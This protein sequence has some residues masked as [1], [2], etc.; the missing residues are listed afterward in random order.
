MF[1]VCAVNSGPGYSHETQD[2]WIL[3]LHIKRAFF[4]RA[5]LFNSWS[6]NLNRN[7]LSNFQLF[8]ERFVRKA[9]RSLTQQRR[10][11][12]LANAKKSEETTDHFVL[13]ALNSLLNALFSCR[14]FIT[15]FLLCAREEISKKESFRDGDWRENKQMLLLLHN[16]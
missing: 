14:S 6:W 13:R 15:L 11:I 1:D 16:N 4:I 3:Y 9:D 12:V 7:S 10:L 8:K 2:S 5:L